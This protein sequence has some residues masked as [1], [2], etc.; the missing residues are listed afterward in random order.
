MTKIQDLIKEIQEYVPMCEQEEQDKKLILELME[1]K[2]EEILNRSCKAFH[3]T[4]SAFTLNEARNKTLM[5]YHNIY[6]SWSWI[7]GHADGEADLLAVASREIQEE[8]GAIHLK[9]VSHEIVSMDILTTSGHYK[10]QKYVSSHLHLNISYLIIVD[11]KD[12]IRIKP[13]ENSNVAW[14]PINKIDEY[15]TEHEMKVVY[16]K[17]INI[18]QKQ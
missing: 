4:S 15:V 5:V 9:P 14:I 13:D 2:K 7:G 6:N 16:H 12:K 1:E 8:S 17:I 18:S 10:N 3:I 11:E